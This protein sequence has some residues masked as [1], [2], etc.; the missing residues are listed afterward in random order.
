TAWSQKAPG[1]ALKLAA[2]RPDSKAMPPAVMAG[3][4]RL[5]AREVVVGAPGAAT[6]QVKVVVAVRTGVPLSVTVTVTVLA[7]RVVGVPVTVPVV[8]AMVSPAGRPVAV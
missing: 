7:P 4:L 3:P 5:T 8:G 1:P 2:V 6:V